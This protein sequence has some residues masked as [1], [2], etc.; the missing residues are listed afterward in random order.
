MLAG[1]KTRTFIGLLFHGITSSPDRASR[2]AWAARDGLV[3]AAEGG[4]LFL[5][6]IGDVPLASQVKLLRLLETRRYRPLGTTDWHEADFRL[7]CATNKDLAALVESGDFRQDLYYRL[8]VFE[9]TL[10]PLRERAGDIPLLIDALCQRTGRPDASFT[11]AALQALGQYSFPGNIRELRNIVERAI[12]LADGP[13][14]DE[15]HLPDRCRAQ[16][17]PTA[18]AT[19]PS[20]LAEAE[21]AF[22]RN[23]LATHTGTR[24]ELAA[25]LG[26]SE[27]AL[28]RKLATLRR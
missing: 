20:T 21:Q 26:V 5:D 25:K 2:R 19:A 6:E 13:E 12:L 4:T 15:R 11:P 28:Y 16:T 10:P 27:R 17:P 3:A 9:I 18:E 22:L 23:A 1:R 24:H 7:I 14:V 8:C